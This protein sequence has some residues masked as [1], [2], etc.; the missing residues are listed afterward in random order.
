MMLLPCGCELMEGGAPWKLCAE[1]LR[2]KRKRKWKRSYQQ[3]RWVNCP[4][5]TDADLQA[6]EAH[7]QVKET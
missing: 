1:A 3:G 5:M 2:L 4:V 7:F 6:F